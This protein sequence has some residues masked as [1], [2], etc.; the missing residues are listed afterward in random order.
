MFREF[1]LPVLWFLLVVTYATSDKE[2]ESEAKILFNE[3]T[4]DA[5][6]NYKFSFR[7]SNGISR[8]ETAA[9]ED[10]GLNKIVIVRGLYTYIDTNG[11]EVF[12]EY[13]ADDM[14]YRVL[15]VRLK[16]KGTVAGVITGKSLSPRL[17]LM[18][19]RLHVAGRAPFIPCEVLLCLKD[20]FPFIV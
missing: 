16:L 10:K 4:I 2:K 18:D 6:G 8:T 7:T 20:D 3:Y 1:S 9:V 14:G 12:V 19:A 11:E 17:K 15:P 13:I 5:Y